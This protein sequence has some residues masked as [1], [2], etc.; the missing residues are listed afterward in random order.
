MKDLLSVTSHWAPRTKPGSSPRLGYPVT[1]SSYHALLFPTMLQ[2]ACL[3]KFHT[4]LGYRRS[5][6]K[7]K[8]SLLSHSHTASRPSKNLHLP[9]LPLALQSATVAVCTTDRYQISCRQGEGERE[10]WVEPST[11]TSNHQ[12]YFSRGIS[13]LVNSPAG[14]QATISLLSCRD[15]KCPRLGAFRSQNHFQTP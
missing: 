4:S 2:L 14:I 1:G 15:P 6:L 11:L 3:E 12:L 7:I 8:L 10:G 13:Q 5:F 9:Q